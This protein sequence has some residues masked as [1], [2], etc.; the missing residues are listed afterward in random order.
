MESMAGVAWRQHFPTSK[1]TSQTGMY[2][3][4]LYWAI[5]T[6]MLIS[7]H[8]AF[9]R[10]YFFGIF[11]IIS[12]LYRPVPFFSLRHRYLYG[13]TLTWKEKAK[14][15]LLFLIVL[16]AVSHILFPTLISGSKKA[17]PYFVISNKICKCFGLNLGN[18]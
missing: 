18:I 17:N 15:N 6:N 12:R 4:K 3:M 2:V 9:L 5:S 16:L 7:W 1:I 8:R 13:C 10:R 14:N 11:S